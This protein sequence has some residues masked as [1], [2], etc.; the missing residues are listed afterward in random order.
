MVLLLHQQETDAAM[1]PEDTEELKFL[2]IVAKMKKS[3]KEI[4]RKSREI[5]S[6]A[7]IKKNK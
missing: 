4:K 5:P 1:S 3:M 7:R 6:Y 2:L